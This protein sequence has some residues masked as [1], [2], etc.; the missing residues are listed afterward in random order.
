MLLP[1]HLW[2][3]KAACYTRKISGQLQIW[4]EKF[5]KKS[6]THML[7][8]GLSK[9][10]SKLGLKLEQGCVGKERTCSLNYLDSM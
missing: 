4:I 8:K 10:V 5:L 9:E 7:K 3:C 2:I 6:H 1:V